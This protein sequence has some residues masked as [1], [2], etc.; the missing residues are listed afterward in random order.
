MNFFPR[1]ICRLLSRDTL[2][3]R[4]TVPSLCLIPHENEGPN[5][6]VGGQLVHRCHGLRNGR[7][8][9]FRQ[10]QCT[11]T[12]QYCG[13]WRQCTVPTSTCGPWKK[14]RIFGPTS[15]ASAPVRFEMQSLLLNAAKRWANSCRT[16]LLWVMHWKTI[17]KLL[18]SRR[19]NTSFGIPPITDRTCVAKSM[20]R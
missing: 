12:L 3:P 16:R 1:N 14:S 9:S 18:C 13:L 7:R 20:A 15:V 11:C 17:F 6:R 5:C 2:L 8:R 4:S 10:D 19:P